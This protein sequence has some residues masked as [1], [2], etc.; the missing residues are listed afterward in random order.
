MKQHA[1]LLVDDNKR[2]VASV[3]RTL[4]RIVDLD[5]WVT[6][7]DDRKPLSRCGSPV[8]QTDP[9]FRQGADGI[10]R[11]FDGLLQF[12]WF[13]PTAKRS[14]DALE[15]FRAAARFLCHW[16]DDGLAVSAIIDVRH[17]PRS[18]LADCTRF[19]SAFIEEGGDRKRLYVLSSYPSRGVPFYDSA[20]RREVPVWAKT[21]ERLKRIRANIEVELYAGSSEPGPTPASDIEHFLITGAGFEIGPP[22]SFFGLPPTIDLMRRV[23]DAVG[24]EGFGDGFPVP[25]SIGVSEKRETIEQAATNLDLD[26]YWDAVLDNVQ[27]YHKRSV[28]RAQDEERRLREAFRVVLSE[29]DVGYLEQTTAAAQLQWRLWLSTNYTRFTD[30][31]IAQAPSSAWLT[32]SNAAAAATLGAPLREATSIPRVLFKLHGDIGQLDTMAIAGADKGQG[33]RYNHLVKPDLGGVY[34]AAQIAVGKVLR[35][36]PVVCCHV[37]GHAMRDA[38]LLEVLGAIDQAMVAKRT[39]LIVVDRNPTRPVDEIQEALELV[40]TSAPVGQ[41]ISGD[42]EIWTLGGEDAAKRYM[43]A[44]AAVGLP[45]DD[46]W[47]RFVKQTDLKPRG[48]FTRAGGRR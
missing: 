46:T 40:S 25:K 12:Y 29:Y 27:D 36:C 5:D 9:L 14:P 6:P 15:R 2:F 26:R 23:G 10:R 11:S 7:I 13:D 20:Q 48:V 45:T 31:A 41:H 44:A 28:D 47:N 42:V 37:V 24:F 1:V 30:R 33:Q 3:I 39:R 16:A 22:R 21:P 19:C 18:D 35:H 17:H 38:P 32:A 8:E 34:G 43:C 4:G